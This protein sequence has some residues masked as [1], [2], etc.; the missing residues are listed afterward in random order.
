[1]AVVAEM[2]RSH[3]LH[4]PKFPVFLA[5]SSR[6]AHVPLHEKLFVLDGDNVSA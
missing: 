4:F 6:H 2:N 1:M 3:Q 5:L